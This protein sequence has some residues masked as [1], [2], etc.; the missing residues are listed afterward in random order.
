[1]FEKEFPFRPDLHNV[2]PSWHWCEDNIEGVFGGGRVGYD[3][4]ERLEVAIP[5]LFDPPSTAAEK[6]K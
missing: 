5:L 4:M 2:S 3:E 1:M 6:E